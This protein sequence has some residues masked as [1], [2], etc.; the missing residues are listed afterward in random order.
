MAA[1]LGDDATR[2]AALAALPAV[3]RTGTHLFH[4]LQYVK[5]F[6]G[7][8]RGVRTAVARWYTREVAARSGVSGAQVSGARRLVASRRAAAGAPEGAVVR[9]RPALPLRRRTG[10]RAWLALERRAATS[11]RRLEAVQAIREM[12]PTDAARVIRDLRSHARDGP[13]R[14]AH[15][16]PWC[17]TRCS[18]GMP[19]TAL[20]R[21][22][23][24]MSK[25][26][27][28]VPGSR[29]GAHGCR[30]AGRSR[31]VAPVARAPAGG[32]RRAEDVRA[33]T[34]HEG[35]RARGRRC[36]RWST[37]WT[38]PSTCRSRTRR[39]RASGS[40]LRST[41][42]ARW[43]RRCTGCRICR[44]ARRRRRWRS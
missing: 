44:A 37:R 32:A 16:A 40:C 1:R 38:A 12:S 28:L 7:W 10:G 24:V 3:A 9:A 30:S 43:A 6:R 21:N 25:V 33:G 35:A 42:R 4:W 2:A 29:C 34:R 13:D 5:A 15:A 18:I 23:G 41:C 39:R 19:L 14:A 8:G 31:R 27:L 11:A 20:I 17:G 26:G 36:R 22:L